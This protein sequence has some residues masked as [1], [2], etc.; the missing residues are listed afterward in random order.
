LQAHLRYPAFYLRA[1]AE[2][3]K[4]YHLDRRE[5]FFAGQDFWQL[6]GGSG[7]AGE[8]YHPLYTLMALPGEE[9]PE[10]LLTTPF[11]ARER[12]NMTALLVAR[13][14]PPNYGELILYELP[15]DQQVLGPVQ[16]AALMEQDPAISPQLALWGQRGSVV[17]LGRIR[18]VPL[19]SSFLYLRPVFLSARETSIPE[20]ARVVVSDGRAVRMAPS[21][22]GAVQALRS[23]R[24]E[25]EQSGERSS[26]SPLRPLPTPLLE[27]GWRRRAL[28]LLNEAESR[29]REGD[30]AGFGANWT[31]LRGLLRGDEEAWELDGPTGPTPSRPT[32]PH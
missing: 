31:A 13:N 3:L 15:R 7:E 5:A 26:E 6:P 11:I 22:A 4:E 20:L 12:Q 2:I 27:Q 16:V 23:E 10:F 14:D 25:G 1:Q 8:P 19:D 30:W 17:R 9:E 21:L 29:L 24:G 28:D 32:P 18:A